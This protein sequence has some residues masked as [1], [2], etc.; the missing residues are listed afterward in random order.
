[1]P[2]IPPQSVPTRPPQIPS[3]PR[4]AI[5]PPLVARRP[6]PPTGDMDLD[7]P[8]TVHPGGSGVD[9]DIAELDGFDDR[10]PAANASVAH[11]STPAAAPSAPMRRITPVPAVDSPARL[12]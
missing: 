3:Q 7:G 6:R 4:G 5:Q 11:A 12:E 1:V 8:T 10:Q 9:V 2:V